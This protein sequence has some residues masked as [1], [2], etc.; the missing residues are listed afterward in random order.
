MSMVDIVSVGAWFVVWAVDKEEL[1]HD[2]VV[3]L[4]AGSRDTLLQAALSLGAVGGRHHRLV[5]DL[6]NHDVPLA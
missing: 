5:V 6:V 4:A 1:V 2:A 3:Y